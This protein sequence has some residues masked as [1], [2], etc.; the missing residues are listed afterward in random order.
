MEYPFIYILAICYIQ[1][2]N[3]C[4]L[5]LWNIKSH[6]IITHSKTGLSAKALQG[7]SYYFISFY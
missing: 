1:P 6:K 5:F 2:S 3:K 7:H 4:F